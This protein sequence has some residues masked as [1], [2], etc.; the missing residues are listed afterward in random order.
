M[1]QRTIGP[2]TFAGVLVIGYGLEG[3]LNGGTRVGMTFDLSQIAPGVTFTSSYEIRKT[4]DGAFG[5]SGSDSFASGVIHS[6]DLTDVVG[7]EVRVTLS[8]DNA[9]GAYDV[10]VDCS[11]QP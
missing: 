2:V 7:Y 8:H 10:P 11:I 9:M 1:N 6:I 4:V 5:L 3:V